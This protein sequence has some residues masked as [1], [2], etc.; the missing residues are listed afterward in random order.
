MTSLD[1]ALTDPTRRW[2]EDLLLRLEG[3]ELQGA[4]GGFLWMALIFFVVHFGDSTWPFVTG[5][6]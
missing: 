2:D 6:R 1:N 4:L 3:T 5:T